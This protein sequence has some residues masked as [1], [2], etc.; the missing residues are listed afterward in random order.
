MKYDLFIKTLER[1]RDTGFGR[2]FNIADILK[3]EFA[4]PLLKDRKSWRSE[5]NIQVDVLRDMRDKLNLIKYDD[6]ETNKIYWFDHQE[7]P[8]WF[9]NTTFEVWVTVVGLDYLN[10]YYLRGSYFEVNDTLKTHTKKQTNILYLT[11]LFSIA[12]LIFAIITLTL[13]DSKDTLQT[14][15]QEQTKQ[16]HTLQIELSEATNL[17]FQELKAKKTLTKKN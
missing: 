3:N 4:K 6:E 12:N 5:I 16:I 2:K 10:Q 17:H 14:Q 9:D 7:S 13:S 8:T 15:L 11:A 1:G